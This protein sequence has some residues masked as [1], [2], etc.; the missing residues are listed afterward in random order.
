MKG[1]TD[2]GISYR[3]NGTAPP[4]GEEED[5]IKHFAKNNTIADTG[6]LGGTDT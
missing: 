1:I 2:M 5:M 4:L 6:S 3:H